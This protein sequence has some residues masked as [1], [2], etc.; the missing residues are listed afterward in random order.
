MPYESPLV[1]AARQSHRRAP[2]PCGA[3]AVTAHIGFW[4]RLPA[5][6]GETAAEHIRNGEAALGT[7]YADITEAIHRFQ[8]LLGIPPERHKRFADG[9]GIDPL[10]PF[11]PIEFE[12]GGL[13]GRAVF[14]RNNE[15]VSATFIVDL[16][17]APGDELYALPGGWVKPA[18]DRLKA[19][20]ADLKAMLPDPDNLDLLRGHA[21]YLYDGFW[22]EFLRHLQVD[23]TIA[24]TEG[25]WQRF[26]DV[27]GVVLNIGDEDNLHCL[28]DVD[29]LPYDFLN[30]VPRFDGA[31]PAEALHRAWPFVKA[32]HAEASDVEFVMSKLIRGRAIFVSAFGD[33]GVGIARR[34]APPSRA[35]SGVV[36]YLLMTNGL[37]ATRLRPGSRV[38]VP[39]NRWQI[40]RLVFRIHDLASMRMTALRD[41]R[42]I[43]QA[44]DRARTLG[45]RLD[46]IYRHQTQ[47]VRVTRE[48]I[49][50]LFQALNSLG[51]DASGGLSYRINRARLMA[52]SYK[53]ALTDLQIE[54][55]EGC[56][57]YDEFVRRRV[58]RE[59]DSI[60]RVG[61]RVERLSARAT[62][63]LSL[64]D[65]TNELENGRKIAELTA[66]VAKGQAV[67]VDSQR[68]ML[69]SQNLIAESE[70]KIEHLQ[71]SAEIL[72]YI[73]AV[74]YL[75][76]IFVKVNAFE[77]FATYKPA[78]FAWISSLA[79]LKNWSIVAV[80][81]RKE[82]GVSVY[83]EIVSYAFAGVWVA[84]LLMV[85]K[86][87]QWLKMVL[88]EKLARRG[89]GRRSAAISR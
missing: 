17:K 37:G 45:G 1:E 3:P 51:S 2:R 24:R 40:G 33:L 18:A 16:S 23:E 69:D 25:G 67:M 21:D 70:R 34:R 38:D 4:H 9:E 86:T 31:E 28:K 59:F 89:R 32:S 87:L 76:S 88:P 60:D 85:V 11:I 47:G 46:E 19:A 20:F 29:P 52:Q 66:E 63:L 36:R 77:F 10:E 13:I 43:K 6:S 74:Y 62:T 68:S 82:S 53:Q 83:D 80:L 8:R 27:R 54:E 75:G 35:P 5:S 61:I 73:G 12:F 22:N 64:V 78:V 42:L 49:N 48:Q 50:D 81:S 57:S 55:I 79:L 56:Q 44:G 71:G 14:S 84:G 39:F 26:V 30:V 7:A 41:L 15:T 58:F 65:T 72:V